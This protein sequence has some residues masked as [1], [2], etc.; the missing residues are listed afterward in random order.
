MERHLVDRRAS[1]A[2]VRTDDVG[3]NLV[4]LD[5]NYAFVVTS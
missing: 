5:P 1:D 3:F 2:Y 4:F